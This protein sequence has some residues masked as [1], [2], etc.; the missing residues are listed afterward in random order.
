MSNAQDLQKIEV[1]IEQAQRSV[2]DYEI[3]SRLIKNK[4]FKYL[5]EEL[6]FTENSVRL[7]ML[8]GDSNLPEDTQKNILKE[9]D[10]IGLFRTFLRDIANNG[11]M[12]KRAI[13]EDQ[14]TREELLAEDLLAGANGS[15]A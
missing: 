7:V 2:K 4:D 9:I 15:G 3:Y 14:I 13:A 5:V 12:A 1:S 10:A 11:N 6:Y 8:R